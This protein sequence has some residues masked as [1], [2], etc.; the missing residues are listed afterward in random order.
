[1]SPFKRQERKDSNSELTSDKNDTFSRRES[2]ELDKK[3][4][5]SLFDVV[6]V[7][8]RAFPS[9]R[10]ELVDEDD[11]G[12]GFTR[13]GEELTNSTRSDSDVPEFEVDLLVNRT[14]VT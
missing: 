8:G 3:L 1:M 4:I 14:R 10:V 2:I 7:L 9:N 6:L 11:G 5:E 13:G 12:G